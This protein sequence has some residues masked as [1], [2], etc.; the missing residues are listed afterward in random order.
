M[1]NNTQQQSSSWTIVRDDAFTSILKQGNKTIE[2]T[3]ATPMWTAIWLEDG[4]QLAPW[5]GGKYPALIGN[6][7]K[8]GRLVK[9]S[10]PIEKA[11]DKFLG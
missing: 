9:G 1:N 2:I 6:Y 7:D 3:Y 11:L 10:A 5:E 8:D 4:K